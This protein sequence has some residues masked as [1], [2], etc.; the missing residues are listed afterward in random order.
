MCLPNFVAG[1]GGEEV[2]ERKDTV[3]IVEFNG[4]NRGKDSAAL[5]LSD[6]SLQLS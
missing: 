6:A 2:E 5:C 3:K 1:E 4:G